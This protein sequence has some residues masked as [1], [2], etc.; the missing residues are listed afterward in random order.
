MFDRILMILEILLLIWI[1]VQGEFVRFYEREV[2]R[3]NADRFEERKQ[4]RLQKKQQQIKKPVLDATPA[5]SLRSSVLI[6]PVQQTDTKGFADL[7]KIEPPESG[8][9]SIKKEFIGDTHN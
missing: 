9:K 5:D 8:T 4:W 7:A 1:V 6:S 2:W 3:M